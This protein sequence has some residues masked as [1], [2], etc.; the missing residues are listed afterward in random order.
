MKVALRKVS[1][2]RDCTPMACSVDRI[3]DHTVRMD[4]EAGGDGIWIQR[5]W[6]AGPN[7]TEEDDKIDALLKCPIWIPEILKGGICP[8]RHPGK[9]IAKHVQEASKFAKKRELINKDTAGDFPVPR[10]DQVD[11]DDWI[12]LDSMDDLEHKMNSIVGA[13]ASMKQSTANAND[14]GKKPHG[15]G[16]DD[17]RFGKVCVGQ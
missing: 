10:A 5:A 15:H 16:F 13:S 1:F 8:I 3:N 17:G 9:T 12:D 11:A 2:L 7:A 14:D 4:I 6:D